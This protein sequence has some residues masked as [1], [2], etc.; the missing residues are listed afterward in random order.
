VFYALGLVEQWERGIQRMTDDGTVEARARMY[1][2]GSVATVA[3][4]GP[5]IGGTPENPA[6]V[7]TWQEQPR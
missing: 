7:S 4:I 6:S 2:A 5:A 3:T 1:S